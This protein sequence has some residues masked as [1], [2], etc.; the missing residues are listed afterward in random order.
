MYK[1]ITELKYKL[2]SFQY[3]YVLQV[4]YNTASINKHNKCINTN[5]RIQTSKI[6]KNQSTC[7]RE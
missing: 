4:N 3:L 2:E 5:E 6:G 1:N 7:I